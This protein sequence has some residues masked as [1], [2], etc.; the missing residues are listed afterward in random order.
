MVTA[1][2]LR[3]THRSELTS[4]PH[5]LLDFPGNESQASRQEYYSWDVVR[6]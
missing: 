3:K 6:K 5:K 1:M 2:L 4:E